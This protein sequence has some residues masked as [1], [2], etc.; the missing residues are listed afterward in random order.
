[1]SRP[2]QSQ[3]LRLP[4][5]FN[6][7]AKTRPVAEFLLVHQ[8]VQRQYLTKLFLPIYWGKKRLRKFSHL[9]DLARTLAA[10][11]SYLPVDHAA[12]L[13]LRLDLRHPITFTSIGDLLRRDNSMRTLNVLDMNIDGGVRATAFSNKS[14]LGFGRSKVGRFDLDHVSMLEFSPTLFDAAVHVV[15]KFCVRSTKT[16]VASVQHA[17]IANTLLALK[18]VCS[19]YGTHA[20]VVIALPQLPRRQTNANWQTQRLFDQCQQLSQMLSDVAPLSFVE[21]AQI[22]FG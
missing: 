9:L 8:W 2:K 4:N 14:E 17:L 16:A 21:A 6:P 5:R 15:T 13:Q 22:R 7:F 19:L 3:F 10:I 12:F 18:R 1:M 11:G 20:H